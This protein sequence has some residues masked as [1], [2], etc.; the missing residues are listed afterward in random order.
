MYYVLCNTQLLNKIVHLYVLLRFMV[1]QLYINSQSC[2][3][4]AGL[5]HY[6][7]HPNFAFSI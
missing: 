5:D 6:W 1:I 3:L 2:M 7:R 4:L